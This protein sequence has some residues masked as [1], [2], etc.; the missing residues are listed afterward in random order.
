MTDKKDRSISLKNPIKYIRD[1]SPTSHKGA[2]T[3]ISVALLA[4]IAVGFAVGFQQ[5]GSGFI[6]SVE[7]PVQANIDAQQ[8]GGEVDLRVQSMS[9]NIDN[10]AIRGDVNSSSNAGDGDGDIP[11]GNFSDAAAVG[12]TVTIT[13]LEDGDEVIVVAR[14][15]PDNTGVV[16]T[17]EYNTATYTE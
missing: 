17:Y 10:L 5:I 9:D 13:G 6:S 2:N 3:I 14:D 8:G 11:Y 15:Q 4:L 1:L 12:D 7:Q 16:L